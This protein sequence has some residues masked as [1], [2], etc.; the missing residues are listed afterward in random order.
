MK[1]LSTALVIGLVVALMNCSVRAQEREDARK[2]D[3]KPETKERASDMMQEEITGQSGMMQ[4][5]P[6]MK[7]MA[8]SMTAMA[9]ACETMMLR[10]MR[11]YP[12]VLA[13]CAVVGT[14]ATVALALFI[15]LE[16][17]WIR[18]WHRRL[19]AGETNATR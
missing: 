17:Q 4:A 14:L 8:K 13:G 9:E 12:W 7:E 5:D 18:H 6:N 2:D 11:A 16:I 3:A 19:K 15:V 10:E 1:R